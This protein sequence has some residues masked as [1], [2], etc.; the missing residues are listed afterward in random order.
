[1]QSP[2]VVPKD[3]S[4]LDKMELKEK[5]IFLVQSYLKEKKADIEKFE[6]EVFAEQETK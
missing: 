3:F 2:A 5:I 6:K 4:V 1:M